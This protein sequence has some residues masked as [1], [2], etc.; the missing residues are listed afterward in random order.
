VPNLAE[1]ALTL[2]PGT[3]RLRLAFYAV[4][5][6]PALFEVLD[7]LD[8]ATLATAWQRQMEQSGEKEPVTVLGELEKAHPQSKPHPLW[9]AWM[10]TVFSDKLTP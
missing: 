7:R 9:V 2:P 8:P 5:E 10:E 6:Q 1:P 4:L 3:D